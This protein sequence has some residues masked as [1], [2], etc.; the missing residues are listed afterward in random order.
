MTI[1][2][3]ERGTGEPVVLLQWAGRLPARERPEE[4]G[5]LPLDYL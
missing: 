1:R 5:A 3:D 4:I 2:H